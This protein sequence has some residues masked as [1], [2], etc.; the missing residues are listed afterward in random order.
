MIAELNAASS[1]QTAKIAELNAASDSQTAI[2][3][4]LQ[5]EVDALKTTQKCDMDGCNSRR[6]LKV[7]C[8]K[9]F[10]SV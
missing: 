7:T 4:R 6:G 8:K 5:T 2:I 3:A 9:C 10:E 1:S